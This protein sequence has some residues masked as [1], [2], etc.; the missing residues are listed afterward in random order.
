MKPVQVFQ[1][2]GV[3]T[4]LEGKET[5]IL[6]AGFFTLAPLKVLKDLDCLDLVDR[7]ELI[8][9]IVPAQ[10]LS[11][12]H[13]HSPRR[14]HWRVGRGLFYT[15]GWPAV[16]DT[17]FALQALEILGGLDRI[18][19]EACVKAILGRH[20]G[21]GRFASPEPGGYNEFRIDAGA[22][23]TIAAYECLRILGALDRVKDLDQWEFRS[24]KRRAGAESAQAVIWED[25]EAWVCQQR[26][27]RILE[28]KKQ[29]PREP[30]GSLIVPDVY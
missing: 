5:D 6:R 14:A 17:Y 28:S 15:P 21:R 26:L 4:T 2:R 8:A 25:V 23:D 18:D 24:P 27:Q 3:S 20:K 12:R 9:E 11:S 22:R 16:Q 30:Y 13:P 19:R 29:N 1:H 7:E 10:V